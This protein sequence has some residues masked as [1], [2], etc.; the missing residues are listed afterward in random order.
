M[1]P[2]P[3]PPQACSAPGCSYVTPLGVPTW[4]LVT[5]H[6][7]NHTNSCHTPTAPPTPSQPSSKY[8]KLPR[9]TFTLGMSE[10]AWE[11][12]TVQWKGY[13][14]QVEASDS[15]KLQQLQAACEPD[16]LR[17]IYDTVH[18][19]DGEDR[20]GEGQQDSAHNE[21]VENDSAKRRDHSCLCCKN[22]WHC[23]FVWDDTR[24]H[25]LQGQELI[26][27]PSR[28]AGD[29]TRYARQCDQIQSNVQKHHWRSFRPA[30]N[31]GLY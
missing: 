19:R 30:Q 12:K 27:G 5:T 9:P 15:Q 21:Y 25:Q 28:P 23:R 24:V 11:F 2:T 10:A 17:R 29:A 3:P 8:E 16:L 18:E 6:L 7:T 31:S 22:N 14:E 1:A 26:E 20:R 13:K 4:G